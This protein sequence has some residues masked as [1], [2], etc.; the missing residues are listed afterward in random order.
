V[1]PPASFRDRLRAGS[2]RAGRL[3]PRGVWKFVTRLQHRGKWGARAVDL[4]TKPLRH[5]DLQVVGGRLAGARI[6]LGGSFLGYLTG[7]AEA[8]V[9]EI[10][11]ELI[12]PG[13]VV[14]DVGANIGFFTILCARLV[15]P[16]GKVYSFEPMPENVATLRRNISLN[17]LENVVV[18]ERALSS[19][20]GTAELFIS[21]W[22]AFHSLNVEGAVKRENRGRDAAPPIVVETVSLDEFVREEGVDPPDLVKLDV[23]GAELV[24]LEGMREV[25]RSAQP[26]LVCEL[27]WTNAPY[28]EF[29]DSIGYRAR[30][31]DA[32]ATDIA[33]AHGNVHTLAWPRTRDLAAG[34]AA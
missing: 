32:G 23:E 33:T 1:S 27:H 9:Q 19:T 11:A 5:S 7:D 20:S 26:L 30:A 4:L 8:E 15:G 13:Q 34:S 14:F 18:V 17:G 2:L 28:L 6:N 25:L 22:S 29:I 24:A 31:L 10:L 12:R 21:P 3:L 16:Q